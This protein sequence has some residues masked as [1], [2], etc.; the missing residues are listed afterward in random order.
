MTNLHYQLALELENTK[1]EYYKSQAC[2]V[3]FSGDS[4]VHYLKSKIESLEYALNKAEQKYIKEQESDYYGETYSYNPWSTK[5]EL[6]K[7][8]PMDKPKEEPPPIF[9][10]KPDF[11]E[12]P[13]HTDPYK[14]TTLQ[15]AASA[16]EITNPFE[17]ESNV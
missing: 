4:N 10:I 5:S 9:Y 13:P 17:G 16:E 15:E 8:Y 1:K 11:S 7:E 12:Y 14:V 3:P 2:S 6:I